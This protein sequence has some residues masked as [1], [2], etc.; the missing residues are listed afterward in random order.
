M[1]AY[2]SVKE[3]RASI[4]TWMNFYNYERTYQSLDRITPDEVYSQTADRNLAA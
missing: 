1:K 3:A 4:K 2:E